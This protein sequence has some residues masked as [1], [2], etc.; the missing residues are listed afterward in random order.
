[1]FWTAVPE[2]F[3]LGSITV[4]LPFCLLASRSGRRSFGETA[5]TVIS[6]ASLSITV[7]NWVSGVV[8]SLAV[9]PWRRA[10]QI[11]ANALV[12]V[13]SLWFVQSWWFLENDY[14]LG[15]GR[16]LELLR[17]EH[18]QVPEVMKV[19]LS[20][21]VVMP[22]LDVAV[23]GPWR[24]LT[25]QS[26]ALASSGLHGALATLLWWCLL[27]VGVWELY[28]SASFRALRAPFIAVIVSQLMVHV[29]VGKESFL[30]T[31]HALP[32][33]VA[34]ASCA[35]SS[36]YRPVVLVATGLLV[37]L[38]GLNNLDQ[39]SRAAEHVDAIGRLTQAADSRVGHPFTG[40]LE[41]VCE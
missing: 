2:S 21:S 27:C 8:C 40:R 11:S 26:A 32:L 9:R 12:L 36:R 18:P 41:L 23:N 24:G 35:T 39:F 4:L 25:V 7:T 19:L 31:M 38:A 3:V 37:A 17:N 6:A 22:Q 13:S 15:S 1:M 14:F 34:V 30:Y 29:V 33:L 16:V 20:D 28:R 10:A 5:D